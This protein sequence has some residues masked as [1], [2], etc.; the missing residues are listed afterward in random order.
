[1][2]QNWRKFGARGIHFVQFLGKLR[3]QHENQQK[4]HRKNIW[5]VK[6]RQVPETDQCLA[7]PHK[8]HVVLEAHK[9]FQKTKLNN[10]WFPVF[11]ATGEGRRSAGRKNIE[12]PHRR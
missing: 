11:W 6:K 10:I 8:E 2:T 9:G 12:K 7:I 1:M 4:K 3:V 5:P